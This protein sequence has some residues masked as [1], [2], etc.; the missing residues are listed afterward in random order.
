M[1]QNQKRSMWRKLRWCKKQK[2]E[3]RRPILSFLV[4]DKRYPPRRQPN[5]CS[6]NKETK[7]IGQLARKAVFVRILTHEH[8]TRKGNT[9]TQSARE[10][11][12]KKKLDNADQ[13][14]GAQNASCTNHT[15]SEVCARPV[16]LR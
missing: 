15:T 4:R 2:V 13:D 14:D 10:E 8:L 6:G 12:K 7:T 16:W 11:K 9:Q 1:Y 5:N 3:H